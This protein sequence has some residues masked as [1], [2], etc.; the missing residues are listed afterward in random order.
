MARTILISALTALVVT[1]LFAWQARPPAAPPPADPETEESAALLARLETLETRV[2]ELSSPTR[3]APA[4]AHEPPPRSPADEKLEPWISRLV[5]PDADVAFEATLRLGRVGDLR[6]A[7]PLVEALRSHESP[8]VRLGSVTSLGDLRAQSATPALIDALNDE[9]ELVRSAA[10]EAL[11]LVTGRQVTLSGDASEEERL[12]AQADWRAW[13]SESGVTQAEA[14]ARPARPSAESDL[15]RWIEKLQSP[16]E[17]DAFKATLE[18]ANLGDKRAA[19]PLVVTLQT[20]S[21]YYVRLGAATALGQLK[22]LDSVSPLIDA[23]TDKDALVRTAA[24]DALH[25]ITGKQIPFS[26]EF[27]SAEREDAQA[28]WRTWWEENRDRLQK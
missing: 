8:Y 4:P 15:Q 11:G 2:A 16:R 19:G 20:H 17:D 10:R 24:S 23:L 3:T 26:Q 6:A 12:A 18:L 25:A 27:S 9:D 7:G 1:V 22:V 28:A 21:D 14:G 5:D 13:W